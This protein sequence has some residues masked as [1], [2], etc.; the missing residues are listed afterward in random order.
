[1][2]DRGDKLAQILSK[3]KL[4]ELPEM[5][6]ENMLY[7]DISFNNITHFP[8]R[9]THLISL[10]LS[11]NP[12][13]IASLNKATQLR[14]L[15][16]DFCGIKSFK[17]LPVLANLMHLSVVGNK[18]K[19]FRHFKCFPRLV[20]FDFRGNIIDPEVKY[21]VSTIGSV[22]I[23]KINNKDLTVDD[24]RNGFNI[25]PIFGL[26]YRS[27]L[28]KFNN[29]IDA[30][31]S[32][33][34]SE[35]PLDVQEENNEKF[36]LLDADNVSNINW[37][38][39]DEDGWVDTD[40]SGSKLVISEVLC[41]RIVR[42]EYHKNDNRYFTYTK[43]P[44]G[45]NGRDLISTTIYCPLV[46]GDVSEGNPINY[47]SYEHSCL[48]NWYINDENISR[49]DTLFIPFNT[50][51]SKLTLE[52]STYSHMFPM[53]KFQSMKYEEIIKP[54]G[55]EIIEFSLPDRIFAEQSFDV[56]LKLY[57]E[58]TSAQ[59]KIDMSD[60]PTSDF[61]TVA[62]GNTF[63]PSID[64]VGKFVRACVLL[65]DETY[66]C[67]CL[68]QILPPRKPYFPGMI[69]GT[70]KAFHPL[71]LILDHEHVVVDWFVESNGKITEI[72]DAKYIFTPTSKHVGSKVIAK[73]T[74]LNSNYETT[75]FKTN[76]TIQPGDELR[77]LEIINPC[78]GKSIRMNQ[79]GS[80]MISDIKEKNGFRYM[81]T[82]QE[83]VPTEDCIGH[84]LRYIS[85]DHD[86]ITDKIMPCYE[87]I[88]NIALK[89]SHE[90]VGS[91]IKVDVV[92]N[93]EPSSYTINWYR[94][95]RG[96]S[97]KL[98]QEGGNYY[99]IGLNDVGCKIKVIVI[100][101]Q[102]T[103]DS[104]PTN[105]IKHSSY[106]F[107]IISGDF[108]VGRTLSC[109][110]D[111]A[112]WYLEEFNKFVEIHR[113]RT[114]KL[115]YIDKGKRIRVEVVSEGRSYFET[116]DIVE[117]P[118]ICIGDTIT[119]SHV[120][121]LSDRRTTYKWSRCK[122][123]DE[124]FTEIDAT[125][126]YKILSTD[127]ESIIRV[128]AT[129]YDED[130][131]VIAEYFADIS[132]ISNAALLKLILTK[133]GTI[134]FNTLQKEGEKYYWRLWHNDIC[135]DIEYI[136][137]N[138]ELPLLPDM[139]GHEIQGG[140]MTD[141]NILW[142]QNKILVEKALPLPT[143]Q[144][145][146]PFGLDVGKPLIVKA[147]KTNFT[148]LYHWKRWNGEVFLPLDNKTNSYTIVD[149]DRDCY[150]GCDVRYKDKDGF[151]GSP[152]ELIT[153]DAIPS[154]PIKIIGN[155]TVG[156]YLSLGPTPFTIDNVIINWQKFVQDKWDDISGKKKYKVSQT[157]IGQY[158]RVVCI[159]GDEQHFSSPFGPIVSNVIIEKKS[160][161]LLNK[162]NFEFRG[163][164][165]LGVL[166][167]FEIDSKQLIARSKKGEKHC[168]LKNVRILPS[169]GSNKK[170][171]IHLQVG[172]IVVTPVLD[173]ADEEQVRDIIL[174]V[175]DVLKRSKK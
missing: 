14:T 110:S 168:L 30:A 172:S 120:F 2:K 53:L 62:T 124:I 136:D 87:F 60:S 118:I 153:S 39:L 154:A 6:P 125:K 15:I 29:D 9:F 78:Q 48:I 12:I 152:T 49:N 51:D 88:N 148:I 43:Y 114:L 42:C 147:A 61:V 8:D 157:D 26:A 171:T 101:D 121:R 143:A 155:P 52:T 109:E 89:Y 115:L 97:D 74:D 73:V 10:N 174:N 165:G 18:I 85:E 164:D 132:S 134:S 16:L 169:G 116:T 128:S 131:E 45:W 27:G 149:F 129:E 82:S 59:I 56:V 117:E 22:N 44:I 112:I 92:F 162:V 83:Y 163:T 4:E 11:H 1:M 66:Y 25:S 75:Y 72:D 20:S 84:H 69:A 67:Y 90:E 91:L 111:D 86:I 81:S 158:L 103:R 70:V 68:N 104:T 58:N 135:N 93:K 150:I 31:F 34:T 137:S 126:S 28:T 24:F 107:P 32:Y 159:D 76:E 123:G 77:K 54:Y 63:K 100:A 71:L 160:M 151:I 47:P 38:Y 156:E 108:I 133:N 139:V 170:I 130:N 167:N 3:K 127:I 7:L 146:E 102:E 98:I 41:L 5:L 80:W 57:P 105:V 113:G 161:E 64:A 145:I 175:F 33:L 19:T 166:W 106:R 13:S 144:L 40:V 99:N 17:G 95:I 138:F 79:V 21:I 96:E 37:Y 94:I 65:G 119:L 46:H 173:S 55:V 35:K 142:S 122:S 23:K 36:I 141:G 140:I 50:R